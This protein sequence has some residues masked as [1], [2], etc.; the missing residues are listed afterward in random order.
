MTKFALVLVLLC[1]ARAASQDIAQDALAD[2]APTEVSSSVRK[3]C[4]GFGCVRFRR[5]RPW[6]CHQYA[7]CFGRRP[8]GLILTK[9]H[10]TGWRRGNFEWAVE[11]LPL[12]TVFTPRR[13]VYGGSLVPAMWRWNFTS[14]RRIAPYASHRGRHSFQHAQSA[15]RQ[16]LL[17]KFHSRRLHSVRI[18]S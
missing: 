1:S 3:G 17:G 8:P 12:Y 15:P 10:G 11:M 6:L 4:L 5:K 7:I 18:F 9:E 2:S 16:H 13:A 14:G